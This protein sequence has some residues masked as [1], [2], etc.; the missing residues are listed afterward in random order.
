MPTK[1]NDSQPTMFGLFDRGE[2]SPG[3]KVSSDAPYQKHSATSRAAAAAIKPKMTEQERIVLD[4]ITSCGAK[5][6]TDNEGITALSGQ[7]SPNSYRPRRISLLEKGLIALSSG[8]ARDGSM[9]FV[10]KVVVS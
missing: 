2:L 1:K 4:Y 10:A 8:P 3:A 7:M 5:G 6:S 9:V